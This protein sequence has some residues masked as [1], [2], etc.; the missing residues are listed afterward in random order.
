[1]NNYISSKAIVGKVIRDFGINTTSANGDIIEWIGDC[2]EEIGY[3]IGFQDTFTRVSFTDY[4]IPIPLDMLYLYDVY[5]KGVRLSKESKKVAEWNFYQN[6]NIYELEKDLMQRV[7]ARS[8][9]CDLKF[10]E[11]EVE[12]CNESDK[13]LLMEE[14]INITDLKN[15]TQLKGEIKHLLTRCHSDYTYKQTPHCIKTNLEQGEVTLHYQSFAVDESGYP[16]VYNTHKYKTALTE[17]IMLKML[18]R[19]YKHPV[20]EYKDVYTMYKLSLG[21]VKNEHKIPTI[22]QLEHFRESWTN[23]TYVRNEATERYVD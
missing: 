6:H 15:I 18:Q 12:V 20:L 13:E 10:C 11:P 1:M 14:I 22:S 5:Y 16:M 4:K 2:I 9:R 7:E 8:K 3:G 23:L 17:F 19:G 21:K